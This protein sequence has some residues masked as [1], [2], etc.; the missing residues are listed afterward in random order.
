[1]LMEIWQGRRGGLRLLMV[2]SVTGLMGLGLWCIYQ[3]APNTPS[4]FKRQLM[5]IGIGLGAFCLVNLVHYRLLGEISFLLLGVTLVL[6][7][8][9]LLGKC[10]LPPHNPIIPEINGAYRWIKIGPASFQ[11]SE[12]AKLAYILALAWYLRLRDNYRTFKGLLGPFLLT[13]LPMALI[14]LEPDLGTVL[15][16]LPVLFT[17]LFLAGARLRHLFIIIALGAI[18][19]YP[20]YLIMPAYQKKRIQILLNQDDHSPEWLRNEGYHLDRSKT[21]IATG[22]WLGQFQEQ[23]DYLEFVGELPYGHNDFIFA[24]ISHHLGFVGGAALLLLYLLLFV[25]GVEIVSEQPDPFGRLVGIGITALFTTQ[26]FVNIGMTMGLMPITGMT[27][28]FVSYGGS[29]L[30]SSFLELGLLVNVARHRP[31]KT[32]SPKRPFE[33]D[34]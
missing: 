16:F 31:Y 30:L 19:A 21:Y 22:D 2:L 14:L 20:F 12:M 34:D 17:M 24:L 4:E 11:P 23:P 28:P 7:A 26:V 5:W 15:L 18:M 27:L 9:L 29:S 6:L 25:S 32:L 8:V 3:Y 13:L 10:L 33:F 1:M